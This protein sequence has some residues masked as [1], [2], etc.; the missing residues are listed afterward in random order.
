MFSKGRKY[1]LWLFLLVFVVAFMLGGC[2]KKKGTIE[3]SGKTKITYMYAGGSTN[4]EIMK[5]ATKLF[6][7]KKP[8]IDVELIYVPNWATYIDKITTSLASNSAP[9]VIVL[10]VYQVGDYV[11]KNAL[12]DLSPYMKADPDYQKQKSE[13]IPTSLWDTISYNGQIL[14]VPAWQ[15]PDVM[16]Y[17]KKLFDGAGVSYPDGNWDYQKFL[18][19]SQKLTKKNGNKVE[20]YGTWGLGWYWNV[21]WAYGADVLN[22]EG[23]KCAMDTPE[24]QEAIQFIIDLAQ[25]YHVAPRPG[26]GGEQTDYQAFMT[27]RVATFVSGHYMVPMLKDIKDFDWDISVLPHQKERVSLN[28]ATFWLVMK[29]SKQ[30]KAAWEYVKFLSGPEV[31]N[32]IVKYENDVPI[33]KSVLE[34]DKFLNPKIPPVSD[35]VYIDALKQSRSF[36]IASDPRMD[37]IISDAITAVNLKQMDVA[38]AMR[39]VTKEINQHLK[40]R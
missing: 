1:W 33:L 20:Q 38:T 21:L 22:S 36:P 2:G 13:I 29:N 32:I 28:N 5:E 31:Q 25:K 27:G 3:E 30:P 16:Y 19:A 7:E 40:E 18:A 15:N 8:E 12:L 10:G 6:E 4:D 24:A 26:E 14:G 35:R 11:R 23:T 37:Q 17:N 9:D 39:K 34:S